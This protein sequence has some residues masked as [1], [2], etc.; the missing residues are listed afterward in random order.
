MADA[1]TILARL[2]TSPDLTAALVDLVIDDALARP[3]P[4][5]VDASALARRLT[6]AITATHAAEGLAGWIERALVDLRDALPRRD[7]PLRDALPPGLP[8][9]LSK[10]ARRPFTPS[11]ELVRAVVQH[12]AMRAMMRTIMQATLTDFG[13]K[14]WS[15]IPDTSRIPGA[16]LRSRLV[17]MAKGVASAVGSEVERQLDDRVRGFVDVGLQTAIDMVIDRASDP[18]FADEQG[19][20]RA[21]MIPAVLALPGAR[22]VAELD[23][24]DPANAAADA[25]A[26]IAA[27]AAWEP[28]EGEIQAILARA[29]ALIA[30]RSLA[31]LLAGSGLVEAWRPVIA[32]QLQDH[33]QALVAGDAFAAWLARVVDGDGATG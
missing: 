15:A 3:L 9:A 4:A 22:M 31:E 32:G 10:A 33:A 16:G 19:A 6:A 13:K 27:I 17:D 5:L 25:V 26:V 23:Q 20:W 29:S 14:M 21:D 8:A 24:I 2:R 12:A 30:G 28:L 18:R 1:A 11:R 7:A